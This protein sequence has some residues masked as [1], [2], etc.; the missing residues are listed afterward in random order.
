MPAKK[1]KNRY[2][3]TEVRWPVTISSSR[4]HEDG[5]TGNISFGG[6]YVQLAEPPPRDEI[7]RM[8]IKPPERSPLEVTAEVAWIDM[9]GIGIRFIEI[10]EENQRFL[11]RLVF[12]P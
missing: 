3:R 6:V 9:Q 11:C 10:S 7:F 5:V 12:D 8:A 1:E 4:G 2:P